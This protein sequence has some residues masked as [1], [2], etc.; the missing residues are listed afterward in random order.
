[1]TE[2]VTAIANTTDI[3]KASVKDIDAIEEIYHMIH[4]LEEE[5]K[6][7]IGWN[8][9]IYPIRQTAED[10]LE[11]DSLFVMKIKDKVVASAIINQRQ[12]V[13]YDNVDWNFPSS[14]DK[15]GVL[16]TLV[17]HPSFINMG[18]GKE[19]IAFFENYCR[20]LKYEVV[21]LDTQLKNTV[22]F[23]LYPKLGYILTAIKE[24]PFQNLLSKVELA[25]FE[26]KL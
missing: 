14:E 5:G 1:M 22:P 3:D 12:P 4:Q 11:E 6:L 23:T 25:I 10:A 15:V 8:R 7:T 17:V 9:K 18:L 26:K 20:A 19:F 2:A 13:G 16:H 24:V 21:R